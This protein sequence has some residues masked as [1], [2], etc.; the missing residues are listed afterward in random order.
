MRMARG[1][2]AGLLKCGKGT[3]YEGGMR[4]PAIAYW[5]STIR[6]GQDITFKQSKP[7]DSSCV[8]ISL[9][10]SPEGVTHELA[11]TLD[12]LPT[13]AS[14]AGAKLPQVWLDGVDM[15]EILINQG[16]VDGFHLTFLWC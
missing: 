6:P 5:P 4:E 3:T 13:F 7:N 15:T 1:G 2:N 9:H 8:L 11:S 10:F 12:V 16:K 14:L